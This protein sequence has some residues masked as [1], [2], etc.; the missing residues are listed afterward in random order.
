MMSLEIEL[1]IIPG[2]V[3]AE[4]CGHG[5]YVASYE[6]LDGK[7]DLYV[8]VGSLEKQSVCIRY[9]KEAPNYYSVHDIPQLFKYGAIYPYYTAA[10]I[11]EWMGTISWQ[12]VKTIHGTVNTETESKERINHGKSS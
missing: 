12:P 6:Y 8:F 3:W 10:R 1:G 4:E 9:G 7:Y 11:L 5:G 2:P